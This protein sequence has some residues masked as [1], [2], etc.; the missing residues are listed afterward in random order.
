LPV[1]AHENGGQ[2]SA[3]AHPVWADEDRL[4]A[5]YDMVALCRLSQ[6]K[7]GKVAVKLIDDRDIESLKIMALVQT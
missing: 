5:Y 4:A 1:T 3:A 2:K 6:V 7:N